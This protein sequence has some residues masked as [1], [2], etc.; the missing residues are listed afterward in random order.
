MDSA[1]ERVAKACQFGVMIGFCITGPNF[2]PGVSED[3]SGGEALT[4]FRALSFILMASR[5]VL[6]LQYLQSMYFTRPFKQTIVPMGTIAVTYFVAAMIYM[7]LYFTFDSGSADRA[8]IAWYV[9][10]IAETIITTAV[11]SCWSAIGVSMLIP[12]FE[13]AY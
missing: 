9:V 1:F 13:F 8:Y 3:E 4:A 2:A 12:P 5:L 6:V 11:A 7:G 10:A